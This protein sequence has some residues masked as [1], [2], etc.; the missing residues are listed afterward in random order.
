VIRVQH[1]FVNEFVQLGIVIL[2]RLTGGDGAGGIVGSE[3][4]AGGVELGQ[5][6]G[7]PVVGAVAGGRSAFPEALGDGVFLKFTQC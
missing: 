3:T 6:A 5:H 1:R 7:G 2:E 4:S